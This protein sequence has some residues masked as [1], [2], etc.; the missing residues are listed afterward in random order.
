MMRG[1]PTAQLKGGTASNIR[2][3]VSEL[4]ERQTDTHTQMQTETQRHGE[5]QKDS[6]AP[7]MPA[8]SLSPSLPLDK[9]LP[10]ASLPLP[11]GRQVDLW[12]HTPKGNPR[13]PP[14]DLFWGM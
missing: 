10:P 5:T 9:P 8:L 7:R 6:E 12:G 4:T 14:L 2:S 13:P 1:V 3:G 11:G